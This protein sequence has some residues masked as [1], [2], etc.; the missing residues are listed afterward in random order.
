MLDAAP[1]PTVAMQGVTHHKTTLVPVKQVQ[2]KLLLREDVDMTLQ[3]P[4]QLPTLGQAKWKGQPVAVDVNLAK[5]V[6]A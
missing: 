4:G 1:A 5:L 3:H 2:G 6:I